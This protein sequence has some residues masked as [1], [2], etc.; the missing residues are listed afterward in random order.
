MRVPLA[1][2]C[3]LLVGGVAAATPSEDA[4]TLT[5]QGLELYRR[6]DYAQAIERFEQAYLLAPVPLLLYNVAQAHRLAG[7]CAQARHF[8]VQYQNADADAAHRAGI[9]RRIAEMELCAQKLRP[10]E[11]PRAVEPSP[12]PPPPKAEPPKAEPST[13]LAAPPPT[14]AAPV[15]PP[16]PASHRL[17]TAALG[18]GGA[19]LALVATGIYLGVRAADDSSQVSRLYQA[20]GQWSDHYQALQ[21]DGRAANSAAIALYAVGG[22]ALATS[23]LL[24]TLDWRRHR[25]RGEQIVAAAA[26]GS[27]FAAWQCAF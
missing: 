16:P 15:A 21:N 6:G 18:V 8:Y 17:R 14:P 25:A 11:A 27:L 3:A 24:W 19:G 12:P 22:A 1:L 2:L 10:A 7:D 4:R 9:E 20:G 26:P 5:R 23:A 13:V